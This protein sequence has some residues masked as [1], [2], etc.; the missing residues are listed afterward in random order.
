MK[1]VFIC[2]LFFFQLLATS[3]DEEITMSCY[4]IMKEI[5]L[6]EEDRKMNSGLSVALFLTTGGINFYTK[7]NKEIDVKIK[8]LKFKLQ[9]CE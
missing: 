9:E 7:K 3:V 8:I 4:E 5:E 6:L 1:I 2:I